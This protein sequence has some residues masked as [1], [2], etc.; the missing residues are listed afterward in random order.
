MTSISHQKFCLT[1]SKANSTNQMN[2]LYFKASEGGF[3]LYGS[4]IH[5]VKQ[6]LIL[7]FLS[8]QNFKFFITYS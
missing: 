6:G 3:H 1:L 8:I 7:N 2:R 4:N 5:R